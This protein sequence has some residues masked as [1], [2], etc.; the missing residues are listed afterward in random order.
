M[1]SVVGLVWILFLQ[2]PALQVTMVANA[3]VILSDGATS[4]LVDLPYEPGAY[5]YDDYDPVQMDPPGDVVSVITHHHRDHFAA[6]LLTERDGWR[7]VGPESATDQVADDR[8]IRGDSVAVGDF[9]IVAIPTPHTDDHRS[10]RIRWRGRVM[11]VV[12]DTEVADWIDRQPEIDVLFITPWLSCTAFPSGSE[13]HAARTVA[14]HRAPSGRDTV[15]GP[16]E[17]LDR[18]TTFSLTPT[19]G[20]R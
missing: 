11:V 18:G 3:G 6:E 16:T 20:S 5:G 17:L 4:L 13:S 2:T 8:V 9:R 19:G 15:C 1:G 12:G 14:Y 7:V 10:Y